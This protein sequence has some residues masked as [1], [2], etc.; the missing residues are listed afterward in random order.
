MLAEIGGR[1]QKVYLPAGGDAAIS[2]MRLPHIIRLLE[3]ASR[4][5]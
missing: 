4:K 1:C 2:E 5:Y 3:V